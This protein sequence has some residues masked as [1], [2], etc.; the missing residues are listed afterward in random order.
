[1]RMRPLTHNGWVLDYSGPFFPACRS[2]QIT[3]ECFCFKGGLS[4]DRLTK[5][6][7]RNGSHI[8][9]TYHDQSTP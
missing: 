9:Y 6:E 8:Y 3:Y 1:M 2:N 4:N 7:H 5:I